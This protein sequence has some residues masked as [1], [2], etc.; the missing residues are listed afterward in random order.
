M[1]IGTV[2]IECYVL[3]NFKRV[4]SKRGMA[5]ALGMKSEGGNVFMRAMSRKGLGSVIEGDL[6]KTL[7]NPLI[8]K[9]LT[10]DLAHG[11]D[12][13]VLI[14]ICDAIIEASKKDKL[15]QSR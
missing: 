8:F 15:G 5:K 11:Y 9:P 2:K 12:A 13:T 3:D 4:I 6:R 7:D 14:D 1:E 10:A